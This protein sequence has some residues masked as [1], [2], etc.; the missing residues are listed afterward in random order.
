MTNRSQNR[1]EIALR[2]CL[3]HIASFAATLVF[4]PFLVLVWAPTRFAWPVY[5]AFVRLQLWLLRVICAQHYAIEG[6][7]DSVAGPVI[8]ACRHEAM[9][10]TLVIP[11]LTGNPVVFLKKEILSYPVAGLVARAWG[12]IGLD[13]SGDMDQLRAAVES[14]KAAR[15]AGRDLLIFPNGT[16]NPDSRYR[17]Q[18]GVAVLYRALKVPCVPIVLNSGESWPF[19]S[20]MRRPGTIRVKILPPIAAGGRSSD[21]VAQLEAAMREDA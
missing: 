21:F 4:L 15:D 19:E 7:L 12:Y 8:L 6:Q 13:R 2:S 20:W 11:V 1:L 18:K 3:F 14:A 17:V 10:E 5:V 16:R 9:W